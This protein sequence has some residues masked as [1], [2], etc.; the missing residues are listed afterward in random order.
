MAVTVTPHPQEEADQFFISLGRAITDWAHIEQ[1][2][3]SAVHAILN[4]S[5][6]HAAIIFYRTPTID[7]RISL[8][9]DLVRS[10]FPITLSGK[11]DHPGLSVWKKLQV[12]IKAE[13]HIRN[14]LAHNPVAPIA[15]TSEGE[16]GK[17]I[18]KEILWAASYISATAQLRRDDPVVPIGKNKIDAH[19]KLISQFI[20]RLRNFRKHELSKRLQERA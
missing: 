8:T 3:F 17:L 14:G 5:G 19:I 10:V 11:H 4:C 20:N 1:E 12:D 6:R 15:D 2:L 7:S 9:D 18:V 13:L 16:D